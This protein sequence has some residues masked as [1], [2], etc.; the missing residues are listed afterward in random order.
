MMGKSTISI[1]MFNSQLLVYQISI[2]GYIQP[3]IVS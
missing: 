3:L 2:I 1:V